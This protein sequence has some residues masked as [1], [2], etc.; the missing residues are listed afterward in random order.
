MTGYI[1]EKLHKLAEYIE[2]IIAVIIVIIITICVIQMIIH[3]A[4]NPLEVNDADSFYEFLSSALSLIVGIEFLK[5]IVVPTS[6]N[7]I[8][9]LL[10]AVSREIILT[11]SINVTIIGVISVSL[12]FLTKKY[13]FSHFEDV[14]KI[15]LRGSTSIPMTNRIA[16]INLPTDTAFETLGSMVINILKAEG[17]HIHI[18]SVVEID[19]V[20]LRIEKLNSKNEATSVEIIKKLN[21]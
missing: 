7:I 2:I 3:I 21:E 13:L 12:L 17:R 20:G 8:E 15:I 1:R 19:N 4:G 5:M 9:T 16:G 18:G 6:G 10:F 14:E 11:H